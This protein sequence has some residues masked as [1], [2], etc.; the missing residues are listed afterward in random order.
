ML[1]SQTTPRLGG[2][3]SGTWS[4]GASSLLFAL[5]LLT[6]ACGSNSSG[7]KTKIDAS[8]AMTAVD[9]STTRDGGSI[10]R[11]AAGGGASEAGPPA[12]TDSSAPVG[13]VPGSTPTIISP[14]AA[15]PAPMGNTGLTLKAAPSLGD[16]KYLANRSSVRL[17]LPGVNGAR[18][19]RVFAVRDGVKV[20]YSGEREH[21]A[22]ADITCAGLRQRNQCDDGEILPVKY[23]TDE[24]D[25]PKCEVPGVDRRPHVPA[26]LMQTVEVNDLGPDTLLVVEAIDR[27][28]PFPGLYGTHHLDVE[29]G[30]G[31]VG[32][33]MVDAVVNGK[34]YSLK[35]WPKT[36]PVRT[37]AE[38][39]AEYG[40]M[41][42]NGQAW[43]KPT[44]DPASANFP[45]SPYVRLAQPAPAED[46][47]VLARS[48]IKVSPLGTQKLP[49]G[50]REVD[51]FDDFSDSTDQPK[52]VRDTDYTR[53]VVGLPMKV[54]ETKKWILYDIANEFSD[55]FVDRGQLHMV[56]GDPDQNSMSLQAFY[57]KRPVQ[58]PSQADRYL[59]VTYEVQRNETDR[60]YENFS[61]CGSDKPND[62][63]TGDQPKAAPLPRP[64]FMNGGSRSSSL[65]WNCLL[66]VGRGNGYYDVPGGDIKA[67][68]DTSVRI[69]VIGTNPPATPGGYDSDPG[70]IQKYATAFGPTQDTPFPKLWERQ[71]DKDH[72]PVGVWL[73]DQTHIWQRTR[74]DV[75]IRRDRLVIYV[76]GQQRICQ[77]M[78]G[79]PITMAEGALGFWHVLYHSSAEF[80]ESRSPIVTGNPR[81]AQHHIMHN[82]PFADMRTYDNVGFRENVSLPPDFDKSVC[83]PD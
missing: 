10:P 48:V 28:C 60:R 62:T 34:S 76:E 72:N 35:R 63:Y 55:F 1:Y 8:A 46:P 54:Y 13:P 75:F 9:G 47:L 49:A 7:S 23:N 21:V 50:F 67:H 61:L 53:T 4:R 29:V 38:I 82:T 24:L 11:D 45:E 64:N 66:I 40:S 44:L 80:M 25:L 78:P 71:I 70:S 12:A 14:D 33:P 83:Y 43:N 79:S 74:F 68:S 57:P 56:M 36:F 5:G 19:Y 3:E 26:Q 37:E 39:V 42:F 27:L 2:D 52:F 32:G 15:V 69:S 77:E 65:G 31:D 6:A 18:D 81:T 30:A 41:I 17:Y 59:H 58:L 51:Y 20:S 73:D 16:I 22:G